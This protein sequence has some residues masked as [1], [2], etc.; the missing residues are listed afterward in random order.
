MSQ[1]SVFRTLCCFG[2][3]GIASCSGAQSFDF[4]RTL[5]SSD[6]PD[7]YVSTGS[8]NIRVVPSNGNSIV[9]VGHIHA[10]WPHSN[11]VNEHMRRLVADPPIQQNGNQVRVGEPEDRSLLNHISIDYELQTPRDAALNL[12]A[13]SGDME[14]ENVGRFLAADSGSGTLNVHG[15]QGPAELH[16]G[17]GDIELA[18]NG[19]GSVRARTGSGTIRLSGLKGP[20]EAHTG[21]GDLEAAGR[22]EGPGEISSGSGNLHVRFAAGDGLNLDAASGSGTIHTDLPGLNMTSDGHHEL[23]G[24]INGGGPTLT[25]RTGSGDIDLKQQ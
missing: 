5:T 16:T 3:A 23:R 10:E 24:Q 19:Q 11:E 22:I 8:G 15:L 13:G 20:L 2:L 18:Q 14:V 12:R 6:R 1:V 17:S 25:L 9:I 7:V 4:H 21:S